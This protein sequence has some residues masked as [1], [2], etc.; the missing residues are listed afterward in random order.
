MFVGFH[1]YP[2]ISLIDLLM[3]SGSTLSGKKDLEGEIAM[4][5]C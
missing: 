5:R 2:C 1:C 3:L 4:K